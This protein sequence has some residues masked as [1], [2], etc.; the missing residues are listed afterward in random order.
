MA[1]QSLIKRDLSIQRRFYRDGVIT[2]KVPPGQDDTFKLTFKRLRRDLGLQVKF[3]KAPRKADIICHWD[4]IN[5][6]AGNA[7]ND[8]RR[9]RLYADPGHWYSDSVAVHEIGHALGLQHV[10]RRNSAMSYNRDYNNDYFFG[11]DLHAIAHVFDLPH[12]YS[13]FI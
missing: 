12:R 5:G 3:V 1:D 6:D 8:G 7:K 9:Y 2:V 4:D 13:D 11:E 10:S